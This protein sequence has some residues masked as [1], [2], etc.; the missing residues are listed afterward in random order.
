MYYS[1]FNAL[2]RF[3]RFCYNMLSCLSK[4]LYRHVIWN[5]LFINETADKIKF[6]MR[7][8]GK[9]YLYFLKTKLYKILKKFNLF[10]YC[11]RRIKSLITVPEVNAAPYGSMRD[12]SVRPITVFKMYRMIHFCVFLVIHIF[13]PYYI[14]NLGNRFRFQSAIPSKP[15]GSI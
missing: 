7:C 1:I 4:N 11:H 8:R 15:S 3:N 6:S 13:P 9:A 5:K 2:K 10:I 14:S 12:F